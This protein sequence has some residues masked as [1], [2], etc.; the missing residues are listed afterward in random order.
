MWRA[1][2]SLQCLIR[3]SQ[4]LQTQ[5]VKAEIEEMRRHNS[6]Q[7]YVLT[8]LTDVHWEANGLLDMHRNPKQIVGELPQFNGDD[9]VFGQLLKTSYY[10]R[11]PGPAQDPCFALL[12]A[13][14]STAARSGGNSRAPARAAR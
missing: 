10:Q 13:A 9:I 7:G 4:R 14:R 3:A 6:I 1:F 5:A 12:V 8:E 11:G 2:E